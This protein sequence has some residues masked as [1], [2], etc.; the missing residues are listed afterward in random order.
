MKVEI[1]ALQNRDWRAVNITLEG[2]EHATARISSAQLPG[3]VDLY[4]HDPAQLREVAMLM[5]AESVLWA[6]EI[7]TNGETE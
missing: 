5:L 1:I 7:K 3:T 2:S 4:F 6:D